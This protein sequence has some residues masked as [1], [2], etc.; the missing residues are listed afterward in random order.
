MPG[1]DYDA[2]S[3][4]LLIHFKHPAAEYFELWYKHCIRILLVDL[5]YILQGGK[6]DAACQVW[7]RACKV[8]ELD[9]KAK[10]ELFLLLQAGKVGRAQ[11]NRVM[12][13]ML[14]YYA[15]QKPYMNLSRL[16]TSQIK[17]ARQTFDRPGREMPDM[18]RW[19]W[20]WYW[21]MDYRNLHE[22][23]PESIPHDKDEYNWEPFAGPGGRPLKPPNCWGF[24]ND[25]GLL[26]W[27]NGKLRPDHRQDPARENAL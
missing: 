26:V 27:R 23:S 5:W 8:M 6:N 7:L 9:R 16:L 17:W 21:D 18:R 14:S 13:K 11:G 4:Q 3:L 10:I 2:L 22:W 19:E 25:Q 15:L 20:S 1:P 12:F 24:F